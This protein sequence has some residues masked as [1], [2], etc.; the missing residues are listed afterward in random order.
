MKKVICNPTGQRFGALP[1]FLPALL[2]VNFFFSIHL[3]FIEY[4]AA[5]DPGASTETEACPWGH[6]AHLPPSVPEEPRKAGRETLKAAGPLGCVA[7]GPA[8]L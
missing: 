4:L 2:S 1:V 3:T 8:W 7:Q 5:P 6:Q